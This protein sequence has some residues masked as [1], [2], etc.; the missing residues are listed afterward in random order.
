VCI[1]TQSEDATEK[2]RE[3]LET[4]D[5]MINTLEDTL[6]D[7]DWKVASGDGSV[8]HELPILDESLAEAQRKKTK[9]NLSEYTRSNAG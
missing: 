3:W 8:N 5:W 1:L 4:H 7:R 9:S 2:L 6:K